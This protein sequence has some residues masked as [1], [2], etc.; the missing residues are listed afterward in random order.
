ML[1][2]VYLTVI[3]LALLIV[4]V[5]WV[6]IRKPFLRRWQYESRVEAHIR[7][8][9]QEERAAHDAAEKEVD[10]MLCDASPTEETQTQEVRKP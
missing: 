9:A 6:I 7:Q 1:V 2:Q 4:G 3:L 10:T 8:K 5:I